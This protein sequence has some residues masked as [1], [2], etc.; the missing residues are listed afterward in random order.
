MTKRPSELIDAD[1]LKGAGRFRRTS[2]C[3][4]MDAIDEFFKVGS[5]YYVAGRFAAFA[6]FHPVVGNLFHH[7]IEMYLKGALSKPKG[8]SDLRKL[9]HNLPRIWSAFKVQAND[10]ALD[11]FDAVITGLHDYEE[12][13]YPDSV[14]AKGMESTIHIVR[15]PIASARAT[16]LPHYEIC[17]QDMDELTDVIFTAASRN[18][19]AYLM[20]NTTA[21]EFLTKEN[22]ASRLTAGP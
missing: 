9:S 5:Q 3:H 1:V 11:R 13:R 8:L 16:S 6:W 7:A 22:M 18:P 15:P 17:L 19:K 21:R 10:P 2:G 20:L 4:D 12:L 14:L